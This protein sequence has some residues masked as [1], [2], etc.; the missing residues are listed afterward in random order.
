MYCPE[1]FRE[2][3]PEVLDLA[4]ARYPLATLV[5]IG[6]DGIGV[7]QLPLLRRGAGDG[8]GVLRGH[9]ARANP[10]WREYVAD[11][12]AVAIFSGPQHY[13]TPNWYPSKEQHGM[14]VPTWNY[15]TVHARGKLTFTTDPAWLLDNVRSLTEA[16]E[17]PGEGSWRVSDAPRDFIE[18][19]LGS[20]V[21][22][23][24]GIRTLEGKWKLSQNRVEADRAGVMGGLERTESW[25]AHEVAKV[26]KGERLA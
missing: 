24:L 12:E 3:R 5:T 25:R 16:M 1:V 14:V 26:M 2:D 17:G 23:E 15:V 4:M 7:S 10:Q 21:G 6:R 22:V 9:L 20:I 18:K 19:Q 13:V 11:S 8:V